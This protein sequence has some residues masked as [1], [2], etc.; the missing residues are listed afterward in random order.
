M[1]EVGMQFAPKAFHE[2]S[3]G[4]PQIRDERIT[5]LLHTWKKII[6]RASDMGCGLNLARL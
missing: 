4:I 3:G 5:V 6:P 1:R 2:L